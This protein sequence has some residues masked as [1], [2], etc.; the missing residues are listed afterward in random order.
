MSNWHLVVCGINHKTSSIARREP[1]Q[2]GREEIAKAHAGFSDLTQIMESAIVSTCNRVE[3]YFVS[4]K[5]HEPFEIVSS[6]YS[7]FKD[8]DITGIRECFY[9]KKNKHAA[10]HLFRVAAG[11]DSMVLG[12][13][14]ILGQIKEAYSSACAVKAAGKIIHRLFHQ[15]F[16]VGKQVRSDTRLGRGACSVSS[17]AV[18]LLR[19]RLND[20]KKPSILFVGINQ[21]I[22]LAASNLSKLDCG[23]F[24]FANRTPESA[25]ALAA[26][27]GAD[28]YPLDDIPTLLTNADAV[29][30][31]TGSNSVIITRDMIDSVISSNPG[32]KLIITDLA[33]PRDVE[34]DNG[35]N[36]NIEILDLDDLQQF[37][38]AQQNSREQAI[39][40]AEEMIQRK[41]DEFMY[42]FDHVCHEPMYNGLNDAF[43]NIRQNEMSA[44]LDSLS[45]EL[46]DTVDRATKNLVSKLAQLKARATSKPK[47]S[48]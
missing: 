13:N 34:I 28:G 16:R 35:Y 7:D 41:L 3:F 22:S 23:R 43:E 15:A 2:L 19:T 17:A 37:V 36:S 32:K 48:G 38:D 5:N 33:V 45:P 18:E 8:T 30:T 46:R 14:E 12:E 1:L 42:W 44:V 47:E 25:A 27:Y 10:D 9:V 11:I 6:F 20:I 29:I 39:P 24:M 26:K 31:C 21:M 4:R 40:M